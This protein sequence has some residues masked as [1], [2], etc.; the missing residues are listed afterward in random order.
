MQSVR[1]A[2]PTL[3]GGALTAATLSWTAGAWVQARVASTREGRAL[4]GLGVALV[5]AGTAVLATVL[6]PAVPVA[7]VVPAWMIA[8]LG[9]G[10]AYAPATVMV[11]REAPPGEEGAVSGSL[12]LCDTLGWALGTGVGGAAVAASQAAG[13]PLR[14]GV[15][16]ALACAASVGLVCL[17]VS[18]RLPAGT[19]IG[20]EAPVPHPAG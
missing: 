19:L 13:A 2:S 5:L 7:L 18:R 11:L 16:V 17:A 20:Q 15:G 10:L 9:M 1:H 8:G 4:V 6:S 14:S 3:T 12:T